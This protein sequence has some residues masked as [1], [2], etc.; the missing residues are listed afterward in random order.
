MQPPETNR[1][2][3]LK[4]VAAGA[5]A[6]PV[7]SLLLPLREAFGRDL[8]G[9]GLPGMKGEA[10]QQLRGGYMLDSGVT[11]LNHASIGTMPKAVFEARARYL[12]LCESNPWLYMWGGGWEE[13][14][15]AVRAQA[16][17]SLRCDPGELTFTH[18]T[19]EA[20]N[21]LAHGLPLGRGDEV[22]FSSLNHDGASVA[23]NHM[24]GERGFSVNRFQFP[25]L[26]APNMSQADVLN[27]YDAQITAR[28]RVLVLPH[29]DNMIGLRH[30]LRELA[31]LART[32]GVEFVAVDA[33]QTVGMLDIDLRGLDIDVFATSPHKWLQAP[34]GLG[35]MYV[36]ASVQ[37]RLRPMW[38]TWGQN[39]WSGTARIF[40]DYGTRNLAEALTLGDAL[41]FQ[42]RIDPQQREARL[43]RLWDFTRTMAMEN[44]G[45][46]WRS[47]N[48]WELG[49]SLVAV[50][51]RDKNVAELAGSMFQNHGFV[52]RAF[53]SQGLNTARL[54]PNVF[55]TEEEIARFFEIATA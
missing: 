20:F 14:R 34:K 13:P 48:S 7:L 32:K 40:E 25:V 19:T 10:F 9:L 54:S 50:E 12:A 31:A 51:I 6:A 41:E 49:G 21:L 3:F 29:I 2:H 27:V 47:T 36:S 18:N 23:W 53:R 37:E 30:P 24:A 45:T 33:A 26:D 11:Y 35:L 28:T 46:E 4:T 22:V 17:R 8:D 1:R 55:N 16:A 5:A 38:V 39:R 52:F 15:E 43:R 42:S 44:A